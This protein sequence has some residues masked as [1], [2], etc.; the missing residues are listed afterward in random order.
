MKDLFKDQY[1][2]RNFEIKD[3]FGQNL[4]I[5]DEVVYI[6]G[7]GRRNMYRGIVKA[8]GDKMVSIDPKEEDTWSNRVWRYSKDLIKVDQ[9]NLKW[10]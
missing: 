3:H 6:N 2:V 8:F 4:N 1:I 7:S 9:E 5:G 10:A